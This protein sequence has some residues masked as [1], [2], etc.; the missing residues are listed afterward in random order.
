MQQNASR[1]G[2]VAGVVP[3]RMVLPASLP[4]LP[5]IL[6]LTFDTQAALAEDPTQSAIRELVISLDVAQVD[7]HE[8]AFGHMRDAA[9]LLTQSMDGL[10][11]DDNGVVLT[12]EAME[13]IAAE[14]ELLYDRLDAHDLSAGSAVARRL[15]S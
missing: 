15:F 3:G 11:T 6:G 4:G 9:R 13:Q 8:N 5:P 12:P 7:R 10:V 14:L 1:L 2:F